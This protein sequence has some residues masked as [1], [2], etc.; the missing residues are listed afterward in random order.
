MEIKK[1]SR[2][3]LKSYFVKNAIPTENNFADLIDGALVQ[4]DDGLVKL[5]GDPLS[6]EATGDDTSQ[7]PALSLY[8]SF[9]DPQ[10]WVPAEDVMITSGLPVDGCL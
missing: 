6:L 10:P 2:A 9:T 8:R 3:E 7:K 5:P 4:R 1:R